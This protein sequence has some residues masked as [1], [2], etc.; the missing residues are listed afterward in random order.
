MVVL[1]AASPHG[2]SVDVGIVTEGPAGGLPFSPRSLTLLQDADWSRLLGLGASIAPGCRRRGMQHRAG[3]CQPA[4]G[5]V[6]PVSPRFYHFTTAY[7]QKRESASGRKPARPSSGPFL[8]LRV[9]RALYDADSSGPVLFLGAFTTLRDADSSRLSVCGSIRNAVICERSAE[10]AFAQRREEKSLLGLAPVPPPHNC[11]LLKREMARIGSQQLGRL[12]PPS[13]PSLLSVPTNR[14]NW[15]LSVTS[16][17]L[18]RTTGALVSSIHA[19]ISRI[20]IWESKTGSSC[21]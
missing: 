4:Q 20:F 6:D 10:Q 8:F 15:R 17:Q 21:K 3:Y 18:S 14:Q 5:E 11:V 19:R 12:T 2:P 1:C 9:L 16:L 13:P 7:C